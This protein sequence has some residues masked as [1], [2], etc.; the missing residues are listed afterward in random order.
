[1]AT[2]DRQAQAGAADLARVRRLDLLELVEDALRVLGRDRDAV[3][4]DREA[5][6]AAR[7]LGAEDVDLDAPAFG[8]ELD[9]VGQEVVDDLG[10]AVGIGDDADLA[11]DRP[12]YAERDVLLLACGA[13]ALDRFA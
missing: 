4:P 1:D 10:E 12:A 9:G 8:R 5:D 6:E 11:V 7:H 2:R 3:V 13:K